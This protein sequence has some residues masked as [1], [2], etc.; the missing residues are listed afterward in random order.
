M[1]ILFTT[2]SDHFGKEVSPFTSSYSSKKGRADLILVPHNYILEEETNKTTG[3]DLKNAI[4]IFDDAH[5]VESGAEEGS[6]LTIS[7]EALKEINFQPLK[8]KLALGLIQ[9][10]GLT[11]EV[12][13][14]VETIIERMMNR[15]QAMKDNFE[16]KFKDDDDY[17]PTGITVEANCEGSEI[18]D[19]FNEITSGKKILKKM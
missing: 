1:S 14:G 16:D 5:H 12:L 15:L 9:T 11:E 10:N 17:F 7:F 18:F 3:L 19:L 2:R 13:L 6:S 4:L 8:H